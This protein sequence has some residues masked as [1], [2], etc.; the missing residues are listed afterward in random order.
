MKQRYISP[1]TSSPIQLGREGRGKILNGKGQKLKREAIDSLNKSEE[2]DCLN[3]SAGDSSVVDSQL[4][5]EEGIEYSSKSSRNRGG[6]CA[7]SSANL[8]RHLLRDDISINTSDS[9]AT[10]SIPWDMHMEENVL[11]NLHSEE[12]V[13][14]VPWKRS[15]DCS[16]CSSLPRSYCSSSTDGGNNKFSIPLLCYAHTPYTPQMLRCDH[17]ATNSLPIVALRSSGY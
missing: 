9:D 8:Q 17:Q 5:D 4:E 12:N 6:E 10:K 13:E 7:L 3:K 14:N 11:W 2:V 1:P 16:E 15:S